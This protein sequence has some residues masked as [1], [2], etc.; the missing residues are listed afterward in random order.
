MSQATNTC[1]L[2]PMVKNDFDLSHIIAQFR[3]KN[4]RF[5]KKSKKQDTNSGIYTNTRNFTVLFQV[6]SCQL[7]CYSKQQQ[8]L[9]YVS[10]RKS[11]KMQSVSHYDTM[12]K[13]QTCF[14][15]YLRHKVGVVS[16]A[17]ISDG[18]KRIN[19]SF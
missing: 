19:A 15:N 16:V 11:T 4:Q 17:A 12:T 14:N 7:V 2:S 8:I 3:V 10:K 1:F 5:S 13:L 18:N 6:T 9:S